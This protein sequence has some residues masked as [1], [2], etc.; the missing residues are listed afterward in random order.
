MRARERAGLNDLVRSQ[1]AALADRI[2]GLLA[3]AETKV[4]ALG[5][6]W[7]KVLATP[8]DSP[9][10][11][12]LKTWSA[13]CRLWEPASRMLAASLGSWSL[14][15]RNNAPDRPHHGFTA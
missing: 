12:P 4:A 8:K 9:S 2:D 6:P 1:D 10:A 3:D 13:P 11:K 15:P 7:D 14:F 5:D